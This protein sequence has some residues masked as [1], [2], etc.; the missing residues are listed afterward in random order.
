[1][2]AIPFITLHTGSISTAASLVAPHDCYFPA[3]VEVVSLPF[4]ATTVSASQLC[5]Q[6]KMNHL[7]PNPFRPAL[8]RHASKSGSSD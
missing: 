6:E 3:V 5:M 8:L 1:M 2:P 4:S 7:V